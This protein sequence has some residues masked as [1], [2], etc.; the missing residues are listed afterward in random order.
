[1]N[2]NEAKQLKQ[3]LKAAFGIAFN[4]RVLKGSQ[5][6][7][8]CLAFKDYGHA[9]RALVLQV[10][11]WLDANGFVYGIPMSDRDT[12]LATDDA[13]FCWNGGTSIDIRKAR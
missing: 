11:K 2:S 1:M 4:C 13:H 9:S 7:C 12:V 3:D 8:V 5:K 6:G 10:S